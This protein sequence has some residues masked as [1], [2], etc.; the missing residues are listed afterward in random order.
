[1]GDIQKWHRTGASEWVPAY[2]AYGAPGARL[3]NWPLID[4]SRVRLEPLDF[5]A[6][7]KAKHL[8]FLKKTTGSS[9]APL[10]IWHS[11]GFYFDGLHLALIKAATFLRAT[12]AFKRPIFCISVSDDRAKR[13]F[14]TK[15]PL[16]IAGLSVR[17]V[18]D[19][20]RPASYQ[21]VLDLIAE[22][23]PACIS[24]KPS[25]L[26]SLSLKATNRIPVAP[27]FV[28]SSG[29]RLESEVKAAIGRQFRTLV[30]EAY[31]LTEFGVV[32]FPCRA[33]ALHVDGSTA[34]VEVV[35]QELRR[36]RP[37]ALG[38]V[39][40]SSVANQAMPLLRYR[41][42]DAGALGRGCACG[43]PA[44]T[45]TKLQ[46]RIIKCFRLPSGS[47]FAPT[48]FNDL[49][50]RFPDLEEFQIT[51]KDARRYELSVQ[52][53]PHSSEST[54]VFVAKVRAYVAASIPERPVVRAKERSFKTDSKFERFRTD[55]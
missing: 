2:A 36:L 6:A 53:R 12:R 28:I 29:A 44:P 40:I 7:D 4:K 27:D 32:A 35:G 5:L 26:E 9:G 55:L 30:T 25:I 15:D 17:L 14:V 22:L 23:Q 16:D 49:F 21:R 10:P 37:G 46:G 33:G 18:V 1:M 54:R 45:L 24:S 42:A 31:G 13:E 20:R 52:R 11:A 48:Y 41:T 50:A 19:E 43:S 47:L 38:E 8:L 3:A 39:V 34:F 51:Q